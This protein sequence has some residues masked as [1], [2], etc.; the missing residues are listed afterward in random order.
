M[1]HWKSVLIMFVVASL[2]IWLVFHVSA[3]A[4]IVG[5]KTTA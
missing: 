2:A 5:P 4:K 3:Y 1:P